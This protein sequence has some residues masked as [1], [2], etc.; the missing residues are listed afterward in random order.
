MFLRHTSFLYLC[1]C[2]SERFALC[3]LSVVKI[4]INFDMERHTLKDWVIG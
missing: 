2:T 4:G 1:Y 3:G